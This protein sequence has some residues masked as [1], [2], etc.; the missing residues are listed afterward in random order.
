MDERIARHVDGR[1]FLEAAESFLLRAEADNNLILGIAPTISRPLPDDANRPYLATVEIN[2]ETVGCAMRTPPHKLV[3]TRLPAAA[4]SALATDVADF[5]SK[6]PGVFGPEPIVALFTECWSTR[7]GHAVHR[8]RS[9]RIYKIERLFP[10]TH[11]PPGEFR[12]ARMADRELVTTWIAAFS[13]EALPSEPLN[14]AE[15]ATDRI[16]RERL[17]LWENAK[18]VSMV[19]W[20]GKTPNGVRVNLVY[21]PPAL[22][23]HGYA[24]A[25]VRAVTRRL[26]EQ[27]NRFCFLFTDLANPTSNSIYQR[28]GYRPVCDVT[29]Y[30]FAG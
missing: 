26:L 4:V 28:I 6:L 11:Q 8:A 17:F 15:L 29:D 13:R 1:S 10:A 30:E 21:T 23:G 14:A 20:T 25:C 9:N 2:S 24:S 7:T 18:P 12:L 19:A 16:N 3:I 27:G 5:Y 22:R